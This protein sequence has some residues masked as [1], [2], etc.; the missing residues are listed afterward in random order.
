MTEKQGICFDFIP[1][2]DTREECARIGAELQGAL[3]GVLP[4]VRFEA[5]RD[6]LGR[7][8]AMTPDEKLA[9]RRAM[10]WRRMMFLDD[11]WLWERIELPAEV[12]GAASRQV[13][14]R[15]TR[16]QTETALARLAEDG[17]LPAKADDAAIEYAERLLKLDLSRAEKAGVWVHQGAVKWLS[18]DSGIDDNVVIPALRLYPMVHLTQTF[19]QTGDERYLRGAVELL[20]DLTWEIPG[21]VINRCG[22]TGCRTHW[23]IDA[24][25]VAVR[26]EKTMAMA[27]IGRDAWVDRPDACALVWKVLG[28]CGERGMEFWHK[29]CHNIVFFE[30]AALGEMGFCFP[31]FRNSEAWRLAAQRRLTG[32]LRG[33]LLSDGTNYE[34]ALGYHAAYAFWPQRVVEAAR[35]ARIPLDAEFRATYE[36][37][38]TAAL[39]VWAKVATPARTLPPMGDCWPQSVR[40]SLQKYGAEFGSPMALAVAA[41]A[42]EKWPEQKSFFLP[43]LRYAVMRSGW[44]R[45]AVWCGFNLRGFHYGHDHYDL[46]HVEVQGG[47]TRLL[48][49]S[50]CIDYGAN[51]ERSRATCAHNALVIDGR[52]QGPGLAADLR[53]HTSP[54]FDWAEGLSLTHE[55]VLHRRAVCFLKPDCFLVL[56]RV[57]FRSRGERRCEF[58]W[59]LPAAREARLNERA[60]RTAGEGWNVSLDFACGA[61]WGL[62]QETGF[63]ATTYLSWI[64]AP[65]ARLSAACTAGFNVAALIR[66]QRPG[67][68]LESG[69][70]VERAPV[71]WFNAGDGEPIPEGRAMGVIVRR[72]GRVEHILWC[73]PGYGEKRVGDWSTDGEL[74]LTR[75][76]DGKPHAALSR[77]ASVVMRRGVGQKWLTVK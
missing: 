59:H 34:G 39:D 52:N 60:V 50:G 43:Q 4:G 19:V 45:G 18:G 69:W 49:D 64:D 46:L 66:P 27:A 6:S 68:D 44:E 38:R 36:R 13:F 37:K 41:D 77:E 63:L 11:G 1:L 10:G 51:R 75:E 48:P 62:T 71:M 8:D 73:D 70:Q 67:A 24:L 47:D 65:V 57:E 14:A 58:Y 42:S 9:F 40:D 23:G 12:A 7:W 54:E 2:P 15:W 53:W 28:L 25:D 35:I 32:A 16:T 21:N 61:D 76:E 29:S 30:P 3:A 26:T 74:L 72:P 56:D 5:M 20:S 17:A 31:C 22:G 55:G 33:A